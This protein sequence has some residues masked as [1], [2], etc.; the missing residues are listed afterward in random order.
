MMI[1]IQGYDFEID[2]N[3]WSDSSA[4]EECACRLDTW[5]R[6]LNQEAVREIHQWLLEESD[7]PPPKHLENV[8]ECFD[9]MDAIFLEVTAHWK[10]HP[11]T[12]HNF[13]LKA[14]DSL[15]W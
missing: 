8:A 3:D 14:E 7:E 1:S 5:L 6:T 9:K 12:G 11:E 4:G 10:S 15:P 2:V 13:F